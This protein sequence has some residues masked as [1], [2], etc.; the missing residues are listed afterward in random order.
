MKRLG[1]LWLAGVFVL[2]A[3]R[4]A[5]A[6]VE[7][8]ITP[9]AP[10]S[11]MVNIYA[12]DPLGFRNFM[13]K[14]ALVSGRWVLTAARCSAY[15]PY[16]A[17]EGSS[18]SGEPEFVVIAAGSTTQVRVLDFVHSDDGLLGLMYLETP[19]AAAPL[20]VGTA[21][22]AALIGSAVQI[23][24]TESSKGVR[25]ARFNPGSGLRMNC[26]IDGALYATGSSANGGA[27][28]YLMSW[29]QT[30]ATLF[31]ARARVI[32]PAAP[33]APDSEMDRLG[34]FDRSGARLYLDFRAGGSHPC[35]EDLGAP[36]LR[37][38]A[39]GSF[40][41]VGVVTAVGMA[42]GLP[43]CGPILYNTFSSLA[44]Y[45][46]FM[47]A[48]IAQKTF[49]LKC[50]AAPEPELAYLEDGSAR[51]H[52]QRVEGASGYRL[53]YTPHEGYAP[54]RSADLGNVLEYRAT[55]PAGAQYSVAV[56]AYNAGC[57][58]PVSG[59]LLVLAAGD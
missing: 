33:G 21:T 52:W 30:G 40:E 10:Q 23:L 49:E 43:L 18:I 46:D 26:D 32:D 35:H 31:A 6:I 9:L 42:A 3:A 4:Q 58:S 51:L 59:R 11:W 50:P 5:A 20:R 37:T 54:I 12:K 25:D 47:F 44:H 36:V 24:G 14:G 15:D 45:A 22:E 17:L 57:S 41:A 53:H 7:P 38:A 56:T 28:C 27:W 55:L 39:D 16:R 13:C 34:G 48:A 29:P 8:E 2:C 1:M 19:I